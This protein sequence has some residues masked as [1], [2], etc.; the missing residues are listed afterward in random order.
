MVKV[1]VGGAQNNIRNNNESGEHTNG[2][3]N[4]NANIIGQVGAM[5]QG[6]S[7]TSNLN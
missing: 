7:S 2:N 3:G 4:S 6:N 1:S 5:G